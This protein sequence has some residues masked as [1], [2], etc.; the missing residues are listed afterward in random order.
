MATKPSRKKPT[1]PA[2]RKESA[3]TPGLHVAASA[4][5]DSE[6]PATSMVQTVV[7]G[8]ID[9]VMNGR[10][11]PGQRLIAADLAEEF[12]VSRAPVREALHVLAG[13][14]VVDLIQNRG[15][16]IRRLSVQHLVDFLEYT[17]TVCSL[18][19]RLATPKMTLAENRAA[20]I[21]AFQR[22]ESAWA[23][24]VPAEFVDSLY[25]YHILVNRISGNHFVDFF[26]RRPYVKFFTYLLSDLVPGPNWQ[27]YI[28]NY[29]RIHETILDGDPHESVATFISHMRWV[30][31]IMQA[32]SEKRAAG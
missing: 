1:Q 28:T 13:E 29:R 5:A 19:V 24:R 4:T 21:A 12:H 8:I 2:K 25:A 26:Y 20:V 11:A 23:R 32:S 15:A 30:L 9:G 16:K 6:A 3:K 17:E 31:K 22:I 14:G 18:G 27:Q 10:Y 7:E